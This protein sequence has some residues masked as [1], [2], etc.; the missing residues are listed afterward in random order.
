MSE[1]S[2]EATSEPCSRV[3]PR[4]SQG[5]HEIIKVSAGTGHS[6]ASPQEPTD[7]WGLYAFSKCAYHPA[8]CV[9]SVCGD[10]TT[11]GHSSG[12]VLDFSVWGLFE[13]GA[14]TGQQLIR[15]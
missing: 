9:P 10:R 7:A 14:L 4:L 12:T 5:Q 2:R 3:W 13:A 15:Q 1:E 6:Q 11:W 8:N